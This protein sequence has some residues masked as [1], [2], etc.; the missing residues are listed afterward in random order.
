[1]IISPKIIILSYYCFQHFEIFFNLTSG[2]LFVTDIIIFR[3]NKKEQT[4]NVCSWDE[5]TILIKYK[6]VG[7]SAHLQ[8]VHRGGGISENFEETNHM[9]SAPKTFLLNAY[10]TISPPDIQETE[11]IFF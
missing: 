7:C 6:I 8:Y 11:I 1:M 5:I 2:F 3:A 4:T 10:F 9:I